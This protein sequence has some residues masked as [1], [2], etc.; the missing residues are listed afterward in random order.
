MNPGSSRGESAFSGVRR[1][2]VPCAAATRPG[3]GI[4]LHGAFC[5]DASRQA[6]A[7]WCFARRVSVTTSAHTRSAI[8]MPTPANPMP[9]PRTFALAAMS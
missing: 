5:R 2:A 8:L 3:G 4:H 7:T 6:E 1:T 9:A